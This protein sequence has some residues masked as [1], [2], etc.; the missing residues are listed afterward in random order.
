MNEA[1]ITEILAPVSPS[2][3]VRREKR[4]RAGFWRTARRAAKHI[5]FMEDVVASYY[6]ALDSRTPLRV[7]GTL[8]AALAYFVM[9]L[10]MIPDFIAAFGFT[11]DIAVLTGAIAAIRGHIRPEHRQAAREALD[12]K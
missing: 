3:D 6:A 5:P 10:D 4:V 12:A 9:P 7:R 8:L 2:E 1:K 11:D